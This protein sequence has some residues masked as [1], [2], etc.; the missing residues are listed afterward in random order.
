MG[1]QADYKERNIWADLRH[2]HYDKLL[3]SKCR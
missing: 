1:N 2:T 3:S